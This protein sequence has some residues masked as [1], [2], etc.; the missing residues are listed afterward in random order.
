MEQIAKRWIGRTTFPGM[1]LSFGHVTRAAS[2]HSN[3]GFFYKRLGSLCAIL[4]RADGFSD[5]NR[6][7]SSVFLWRHR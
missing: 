1:R 6:E 3:V 4:N 5:G 2:K 7:F